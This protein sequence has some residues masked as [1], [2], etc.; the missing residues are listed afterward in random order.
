MILLL[1][2]S[3]KAI[4]CESGYQDRAPSN[5][6]DDNRLLKIPVIVHVLY[7]NDAE[8]VGEDQ[9]NQ[10]IASLANDFRGNLPAAL[11]RDGI[12]P[13]QISDYAPRDTRITFELARVLPDGAITEGILYTPTS[14]SVFRYQQRKP[15]AESPPVDPY[16]YL[17][18]YICDTNT[19]AYTPME[20]GNHGVVL[21][22]ENAGPD[23][24]TLTHEVGHWLGLY[25]IFE[26]GCND[27]DGIAD[28]KAQKK[29]FGNRRYPFRSCTNQTMVTNFMGY[30]DTRDFFTEGQVQA[31]RKF[32]FNYMELEKISKSADALALERSNVIEEAII[33]YFSPSDTGFAT[34][35]YSLTSLIFNNQVE[36]EKRGMDSSALVAAIGQAPFES[37]YNESA[38]TITPFNWQAAVLNELATIIAANLERE[39][40]HY[41]LQHLFKNVVRPNPD[42]PK[43]VYLSSTFYNMFPNAYRYI[44]EL[45][46]SEATAS[47]MNVT[48]LQAKIKTDLVALPDNFRKHPETVLTYLNKNPDLKDF[49]TLANA[50]YEGASLGYPLPEIVNRISSADYTP[51]SK[52]SKIAST[53]SVI[54]NSIELKSGQHLWLDPVL[55]LH[56][57]KIGDPVVKNIYFALNGKLSTIDFV[58]AYL[59]SSSSESERINRIYDLLLVVDKLNQSYHYLS[60]KDFKL[61]KFGEQMAYILSIN[62]A[63]TELMDLIIKNPE[64]NSSITI[65]AGYTRTVQNIYAVLNSFYTSQYPEAV[66]SIITYFSPY[67]GSYPSNPLVLTAVKIATA[68]DDKDVKAILKSYIEPIGSSSQKRTS[69]FNISIN[70]Y[71]GIIGG[72]EDIRSGSASDSYY[73]GI[74]APVGIAFSFLPSRTG[75]F[76]LFAEV[77]DLGSL[78]N[79][80]LK[81]DDTSYEALKFEHFL[82]PGIGLFYNFKNSPLTAGFKYNYLSNLRNI[83]YDGVTAVP[84]ASNR[85][86]SRISFSLLV[87]IPLFKIL[88][89]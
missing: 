20:K 15:F 65:G 83:E 67:L 17:N 9:I 71:A 33:Q 50:L 40:S 59:N 70:S 2:P 75:S 80:R 25:H 10:L 69:K 37:N 1:L 26:G 43:Q 82:T 41:A 14:T 81:D 12:D 63:Y 72:Y 68:K 77:L 84:E 76:S 85:D 39:V 28:T 78:V 48:E 53:L 7:K 51:D 35:Y 16:H 13:A 79:V 31:M 22:Y 88:S 30:N 74:S 18:V 49:F 23:G 86:A 27:G 62:E 11:A 57:S 89:K 38:D 8:K 60:G 58:N 45:Y 36:F 32:I 73:G 61:L 42:Q 47:G 55:Y 6:P 44:R 56:P 87:D 19:G 64:L 66:S 52:V 29:F 34:Q 46:Y 21:D 5:I 54:A 24:N 4:R 3:C